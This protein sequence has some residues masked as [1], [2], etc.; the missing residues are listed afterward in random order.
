MR[1]ADLIHVRGPGEVREQDE[2][3]K[4][5]GDSFM[6]S[7]EFIQIILVTQAVILSPQGQFS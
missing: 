2:K 1:N 6:H 5:F 7:G 4:R 3:D